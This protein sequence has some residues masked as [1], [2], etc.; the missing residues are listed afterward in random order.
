MVCGIGDNSMHNPFRRKGFEVSKDELLL[1]TLGVFDTHGKQEISLGEIHD[2]ILSIQEEIPLGYSFSD[3]V[4]YSPE[5]MDTL[6]KLSAEGLVHRYVYR[7][8]AFLPTTFVTMTPLGKLRSK[9]LQ[10]DV[11]SKVSSSIDKAVESAIGSYNQRW[12]FW[13]R[14]P[15]RRAP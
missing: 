5:V 6:R 15:R 8:D 14:E 1:V 3:A 2:S 7:E 11:S 10:S 13:S 9:K 4:L 12:R